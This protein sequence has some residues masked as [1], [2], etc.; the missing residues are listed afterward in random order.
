MKIYKIISY[1]LFFLFGITLV[2]VFSGSNGTAE[3]DFNSLFMAVIAFG[4]G[5]AFML[6]WRY[7][8][9][10]WNEMSFTEQCKQMAKDIKSGKRIWY[11]NPDG[12]DYLAVPLSHKNINEFGGGVHIVTSLSIIKDLAKKG[13]IK[14]E[15]LLNEVLRFLGP[16]NK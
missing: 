2:L 13:K 8:P 9:R 12:A 10:P 15:S 4:L 16:K 11:L 5:C 3:Q 14:N 7:G 1:L 6:Y